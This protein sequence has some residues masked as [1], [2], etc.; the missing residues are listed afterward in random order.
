MTQNPACWH[1]LPVRHSY[2][3]APVTAH[4]LKY[5]PECL[6][7]GFASLASVREWMLVFETAYNRQHLYGSINFVTSHDRHSGPGRERVTGA[8]QTG[9]RAR[10]S[11]TPHDGPEQP[12]PGIPQGL[13]D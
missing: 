9:M 10:N 1:K 12:A 4:T 6:S 8:A 13:G 3:G 11:R 2:N 7:K 5:R